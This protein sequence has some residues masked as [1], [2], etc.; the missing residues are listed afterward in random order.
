MAGFAS[1]RPRQPIG[2]REENTIS[3]STD[4]EIQ[5]TP[6][7]V[8]RSHKTTGHRPLGRASI[9]QMVGY[10][11]SVSRIFGYQLA[12]STIDPRP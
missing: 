9:G 8:A 12:G 7:F 2:I 6:R 5:T 10:L 4:F 3:A 11:I 1:W